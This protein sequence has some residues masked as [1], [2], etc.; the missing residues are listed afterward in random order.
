MAAQGPRTAS[1]T[2]M[3]RVP[4]V[5]NEPASPLRPLSTMP[6]ARS[7]CDRRDDGA[8]GIRHAWREAHARRWPCQHTE[9]RGQRQKSERSVTGAPIPPWISWSLCTLKTRA[10]YSRTVGAWC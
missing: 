10:R 3:Y 2:E 5:V 9:F 6:A 4:K 7:G 1:S 8:H